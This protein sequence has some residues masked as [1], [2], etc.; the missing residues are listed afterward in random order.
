MPR[1]APA[2]RVPAPPVLNQSQQVS[3]YRAVP[4]PTPPSTPPLPPPRVPPHLAGGYPPQ[5]QT[6]T[7]E[8]APL[9]SGGALTLED[10]MAM[11]R[12][13]RRLRADMSDN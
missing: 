4:T 10:A 6:G 9:I 11:R 8:I 7:A 1:T 2:N 13:Q 3:Q 12:L 5:E